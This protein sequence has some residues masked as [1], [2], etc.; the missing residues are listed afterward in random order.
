VEEK[1]KENFNIVTNMNYSVALF[2]SWSRP[3]MG[4]DKLANTHLPQS[5]HVSSHMVG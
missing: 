2:S 5:R 4:V 3:W 1:E